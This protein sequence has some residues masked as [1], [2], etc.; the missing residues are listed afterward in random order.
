VGWLTVRTVDLAF[1][2]AAP[3]EFASSAGV[4]RSFCGSCGTPLTYRNERR[5]GEVD[6]TLC[7]LDEPSLVAPTDHIWM[8]DAPDWDSSSEGLPRHLQG[9]QG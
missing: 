4:L 2:G 5:A 3:H 6:V 8:Q 1:T 9:R 7:T